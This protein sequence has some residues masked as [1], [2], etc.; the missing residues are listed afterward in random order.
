[1]LFGEHKKAPQHEILD[2]L[3]SPPFLVSYIPLRTF[4]SLAIQSPWALASDFQFN[5]HFPDGRTH[6]TSDQLVAK[7]LPKHR[8]TRTQN[9]HINTP[10]IHTFCGIRTHETGFRSSE[11]STCLRPLGYRDRPLVFL[12]QTFSI[13]VLL[14]TLASN[15]L[16]ICSSQYLFI[17]HCQYIFFSV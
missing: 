5:D 14:S 11:D 7:P 2:I 3:L 6:W 9:K 1:M 10:N 12:P 13:Y 17:K 8:I 16:N 15:I 4:F